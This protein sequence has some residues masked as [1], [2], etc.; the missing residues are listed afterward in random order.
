MKSEAHDVAQTSA[1]LMQVMKLPAVDEKS[2]KVIQAYLARDPEDVDAEN[3]ALGSPQAAAFE[4]QSQGI[5]DLFK[6]LQD[7][8]EAKLADTQ[9]DELASKNAHE[10]YVAGLEDQKNTASRSRE[11]KSEAKAKALM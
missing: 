1:A 4:F 7:K 3:L 6:K 9:K 2:K 10:M 11:S 5:V 8:F